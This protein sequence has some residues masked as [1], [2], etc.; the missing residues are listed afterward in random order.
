[1]ALS[2]PDCSNNNWSSAADAIGFLGR[3][4]S[5]GFSGMCHKVSEGNYYQDPYWP[6]VRDWCDRN[7]LPLI[8]YHYVTTNN[9]GD[10]ARTWQANNGGER[11]MLEWET[12]G[13]DL[14]NLA[15]VVDAFNA[16]GT[17]VQLGYYPYWYWQQQGGGGLFGLA[18]AVVS[19]AYPNGPGFASTIYADSG[20]NRGAGW[21]PYGGVTPQ[22]WQFTDRARIAGHIV[23]CNA[24]Q[25]SDITV[26]FGT[27]VAAIQPPRTVGGAGNV[28]AKF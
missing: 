21:A 20:G 4:V 25:G 24:Y 8:G 28:D 16:A 15:A 11:A 19:S 26:L 1:M 23:D 7:G 2:Y 14:V 10:Q 27:T 6:S 3:L 18:S 13:G 9:P 17:T 12:G 5:D 22:A